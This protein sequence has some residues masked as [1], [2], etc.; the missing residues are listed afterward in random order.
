M[1]DEVENGLHPHLLESL[2][3]L[4]H[5]LSEAG[6]QVIATTHSPIA[7]NYVRDASQV[8]IATRDVSTG[9]A[10]LTPMDRAPGYRK[11]RG[12]MDPGEAWYNLGEERLLGSVR[13]A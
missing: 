10:T 6:T 5:G 1:I 7:L 13:K 4:L 9:V 11:V 8:L 2:V 3:E 12:A